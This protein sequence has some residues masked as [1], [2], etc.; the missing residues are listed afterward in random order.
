MIV[1]AI[2]SLIML[3]RRFDAEASVVVEG[4]LPSK[5]DIPASFVDGIEESERLAQLQRTI[6]SW[7][8]KQAA[9]QADGGAD[10]DSAFQTHDHA[11]EAFSHRLTCSKQLALELTSELLGDNCT[12]DDDIN[13]RFEDFAHHMQC[14]LISSSACALCCS[15]RCTYRAVF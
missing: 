5:K 9:N 6:S 15:G 14:A 7:M 10:L 13:K 3:C 1:H 12:C 8:E 2:M 11:L 4:R